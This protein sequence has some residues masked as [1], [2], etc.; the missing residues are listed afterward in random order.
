MKPSSRLECRKADVKGGKEMVE[1]VQQMD[2]KLIYTCIYIKD[3]VAKNKSK[4]IYIDILHVWDS[5]W[6]SR[7]DGKLEDHTLPVSVRLEIRET[8]KWSSP[9]FYTYCY[10]LAQRSYLKQVHLD[11]Y[12]KTPQ[13][14]NQQ[15]D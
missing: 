5:E 1:E 12:N 15:M 11:M 10:I 4:Q 13:C 2:R 3:V 8:S 9:Y 6:N 14:S 7:R